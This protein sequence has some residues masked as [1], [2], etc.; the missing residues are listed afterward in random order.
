M[1]EFYKNLDIKHVTSCIEHYQTNGQAE[2][3]NKTIIVELKHRL[4]DA[5]GGWVDEL[6]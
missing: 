1:A 6:P 2:A 3:M 5:K 4:V